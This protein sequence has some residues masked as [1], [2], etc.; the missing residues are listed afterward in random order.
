MNL[1]DDT[2]VVNFVSLWLCSDSYA[3]KFN[4]IYTA[5]INCYDYQQSKWMYTVTYHL[6]QQSWINNNND[7]QKNDVHETVWKQIK[8]NDLALQ[9][10]NRKNNTFTVYS[11]KTYSTPWNEQLLTFDCKSTLSYTFQWISHSL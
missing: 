4:I 7:N 9:K 2:F 5:K 3:M 8:R 11:K 1:C 10:V 6:I